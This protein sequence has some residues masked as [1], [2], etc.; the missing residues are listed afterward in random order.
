MIEAQII[1]SEPCD[2][3][4]L[5]IIGLKRGEERWVALSTAESSADLKKEQAKGNLRVYR[6]ARRMEKAPKRPPPP[7]VTRSRPT[8]PPKAEPI[9]VERVVEVERVEVVKQEVDTEKLRAEILAELLPGVRSAVAEEMGKIAAS[10]EATQPVQEAPA[11]APGIDASQLENALENVM[12]RVM[13]AGGAAPGAPGAQRR[14]GPEEPMFIPS[15]IVKKD[16]K[17]K[18]D[19]K[20]KKSGETGDLDDAQAALRAMKRQKRGRKSKSEENEP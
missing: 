2:I 18:I 6:K 11:A 7:F 17:A 5:G 4:D 15:E 20:S 9:V 12:R 19:V 13:P 3:P 1:C 8:V 10:Q 14:S 16:T